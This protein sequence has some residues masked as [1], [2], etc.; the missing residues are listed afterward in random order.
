MVG[1]RDEAFER[2][3][4]EEFLSGQDALVNDLASAW[5]DGDLPLLRRSAHTLKSQA[6]MFGA[7]GLVDLC[8]TLENAAAHDGE[9]AGVADLVA[10]TLR[11]AERT[12]E[13][14]REF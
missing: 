11:E 14:V 7:V 3:L 12:V 13:A 6:A 4:V 8:R 5:A 9:Q 10:A 1:D 2:D